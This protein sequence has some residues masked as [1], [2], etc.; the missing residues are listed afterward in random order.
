MML[1]LLCVFKGQNMI[2]LLVPTS[3]KVNK[4]LQDISKKLLFALNQFPALNA[5]LCTSFF[6]MKTSEIFSSKNMTSGSEI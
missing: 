5:L 3:P 4:P 2:F 6:L 1:L